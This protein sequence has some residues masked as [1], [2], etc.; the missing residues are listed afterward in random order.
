MA[1]QTPALSLRGKRLLEY[2]PSSTI[3]AEK[4]IK[5]S[6]TFCSGSDF[7]GVFREG[8]P[9]LACSMLLNK[10]VAG[11][12]NQAKDVHQQKAEPDPRLGSTEPC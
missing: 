11:C 10:G 12:A 5:T 1:R 4:K 6:T 7:W 8:R 3:I 2:L 9:A